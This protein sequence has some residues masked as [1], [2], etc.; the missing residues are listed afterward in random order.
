[1]HNTHDNMHARMHACTHACMHNS[2]NMHACLH[3]GTQARTHARTHACI[4]AIHARNAYTQCIHACN[5]LLSA[6]IVLRSAGLLPP[7]AVD[8]LH[9]GWAL[10]NGQPSLRG[11][12]QLPPFSFQ[13]LIARKGAYVH[14][15]IHLCLHSAI[16]DFL[17]VLSRL[18]GP[19]PSIARILCRA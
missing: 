6:G 10:W 5:T 2:H 9:R 1:M 13:H 15:I 16:P 12:A 8:S 7:A 4:H 3:A 14:M 19:G 11:I 17:R 18:S